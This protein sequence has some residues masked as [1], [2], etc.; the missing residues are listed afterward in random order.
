[1]SISTILG[2]QTRRILEKLDRQGAMQLCQFPHEEDKRE[3]RRLEGEGL[4]EINA[5]IGS[6]P[7][8]RITKEGREALWQEEHKT[9]KFVVIAPFVNI[10]LD[11]REEELMIHDIL[12][13]ALYMFADCRKSKSKRQS[14][15]ADVASRLHAS[16]QHKQLK[17]CD[18]EHGYFAVRSLQFTIDEIKS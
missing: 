16:L 13:D 5:P 18:D 17:S 8:F 14:K 3:L 1:M 9:D 12:M 7:Y 10:R 2:T 15:R 11:S 4:V 6:A